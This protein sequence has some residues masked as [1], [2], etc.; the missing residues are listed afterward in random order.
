MRLNYSSPV[1]LAHEI[2]KEVLII[3]DKAVDAT[4]GNGKDTLFLARTV[5]SSGK[6]T[7]IDCQIEAIRATRHYLENHGVSDWV[8]LIHAGHQHMGEF[9]TEPVKA[10][11]FNLGYLPGSNKQVIT[12]KEN[13]VCAVKK[14]LELLM[15]DG[16]VTIVVYPRHPGGKEEAHAIE[17]F[18][19]GLSA[20]VF[21]VVR[22]GY[23]NRKDNSPYL[24]TVYKKKSRF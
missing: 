22:V 17:D 14:A 21:L 11:M 7:A 19:H 20:K 1:E 3:G 8:Q 6:V 15:D 4:A 12:T 13:T 5:G 16:V 10:V 18:L 24:I 23:I 9:I 2:I